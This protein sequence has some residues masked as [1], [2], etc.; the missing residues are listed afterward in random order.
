MVTSR[1]II[2]VCLVKARGIPR[3]HHEIKYVAYYK[4][5]SEVRISGVTR[6]VIEKYYTFKKKSG[7]RKRQTSIINRL[8]EWLS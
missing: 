7:L 1:T 4:P 2:S 5:G 6:E 8:L 3:P